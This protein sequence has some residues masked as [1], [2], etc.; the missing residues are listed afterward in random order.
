[1]KR[2]F[3][4]L[5]IVTCCLVVKLPIAGSQ[6][7]ETLSYQGVLGTPGGAI[8]T[9]GSYS[10]TFKLYES[11]SGGTAIW[12]E[13][14][15]VDVVN[16]IFS[17]ILGKTNP[18]SLSFNVPY[19]LGMSVNGGSEL[20]PRTELTSA[21]YS[22]QARSVID[23]AITS[24][25]I[26]SGQVV[27]S[28][29][30]LTDAVTL[31]A[32]DNITITPAGNT[33]TIS[34]A[35]GG[36]ES[37]SQITSVAAGEGLTGGGASG[38][39][40]LSLANNGVTTDKLNDGSVNQTKLADGAI[41]SAKI[42]QAAVSADK[43]AD[44]QVVKSINGL[45]DDIV[46][47]AQGGATLTTSGDTLTISASSNA[48]SSGIQGVQN[49]DNA[50]EISD[51]NGP[52]ATINVKPFGI[53]ASHLAAAAVTGDKIAA[54]QVVKSINNLQDN[55]IL[56][57]ADN[58]TVTQNGDTLKI[59]ASGGNRLDQ[60]YDQGG[61]GAGRTIVAD[62]GAV[63]I[64]GTGGLTV[65]GS[66]GI[67]TPTP[68]E[69]LHVSGTALM[70]GFKLSTNPA[71]GYVLK[72]DAA[73]V[74]SWQPDTLADG[75][76]T[77]AKIAAGQVVKS[78]NQ[79]TEA[80][81][82][83][84]EGGATITTQGDTLI[85]NAGSGGQGTGIQGLQNTNN[86]LDVFDPNGPTATV[87]LKELG[88][89]SAFL[90][91][92]SIIT[93][94]LSANAITGDKIA[95][96]QVVK[97][98][99]GLKDNLVLY[100]E[101]NVTVVQAGDT[102][103]IA[104]IGGNR[105]DQAYDQ[106]GAGAGRTIV[107]DAGAVDISSTGGLTVEGSV[108]IG[109]P[110]P[111][112]KLHVSGTALMTGFKLSTNPVEGYV[113]KSDAAGVGSWQPDTLTDG[114]VTAD[115]IA[116]GQVVKS[117]NNLRDN[118]ILTGADNVTVTQN[119][120]TLKIAASGGNRLN[121]AYDQG[122]AGAGR[123]IV[124]DA[125]AVDISGAG[126]LTVE[127]SVGIGT[128][129]PTEKLHVLGTALMTGFKLSTNPV[130][131]YV[132]KSDVAG[133][134]SWQPDTLADGSVTA[135]KIAA[136]Q[137][138]KSINQ[139]TEAVILKAEGGATIT[140][141]GDTL[142]IN[143]GSGGTLDD[144]YDKG[145]PGLG[146]TIVADAGPVAIV[147]GGDVLSKNKTNLITALAPTLL[148]VSG[149]IVM[150]GLQLNSV[151][152]D[153]FVL[154]SDA[155]GVASWQAD[156]LENDEVTG[157]KI[158][159][160]AVINSDL[161]D[162]SV[163]TP[164]LQ[165][166]VVTGSKIAVNQVVRSMNGLTE[167]VLVAGGDNVTVDVTGNTIRISTAVPGSNSW[168]L[169]GNSGTSA[170]SH[171]LGT[172]DNQPLEIHVNS[173]RVL[174]L[175]PTGGDGPNVIAGISANSVTSGVVGAT[176][177]G[178]GAS[179]GVKGLIGHKITD[180]YGTV[181]GGVQNQA[182]DNSGTTDDKEYATVGGG[183]AN[184]AT[185]R[186]STISGGQNNEASGDYGTVPGGFANGAI[187]KYSYAAGQRA[188]ANHDGT[189]V[190]ADKTLA[191][192]VSTGD[193]QFLIRAA[194]GVGIGTNAP[195]TALHITS[196]DARLRLDD[197]QD[198]WDLYVGLEGGGDFEIANAG[199]QSTA[200]LI[201][202]GTNNVG[203][204]TVTPG[205]RLDVAGNVHASGSIRSGNSITLDGNGE[206]DQIFS[207]TGTLDFSNNTLVTSGTV[208]IGGF[209]LTASP[210]AGSVLKSDAFGNGAWQ[211]DTLKNNSVTESKI[212]PGQVVRK[213]NSLTDDVK[214]AGGQIIQVVTDTVSKTIL[215]DLISQFGG[216]SSKRWK[217]NIRPIQ[218]ALEKVKQLQGVSYD[219]KKDGSHDIGLIAEEV[220]EIVPE[221]VTYEE[222]GIDA[223]IVNYPHLVA[224]LIESIKEQQKQIDTLR[225]EMRKLKSK[226]IK[227]ASLIH[228][229]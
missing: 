198:R 150:T 16:G 142:I 115:K 99:N 131:G 183:S 167:D 31:S 25:K 122:G 123:T 11:R 215:I 45:K 153:G 187:G 140:T 19:W 186:H 171:F 33:L 161:A 9:D 197:G 61:A 90:A 3:H 22:M 114:S 42:Q 220:G 172:T 63:D 120:D 211:P 208:E 69:K 166:G 222:N 111:T 36:A 112:E 170:S 181:A 83:K 157:A 60:A 40:T 176:I 177:G 107:A 213:V 94:K 214:I 98:I 125:G 185:G 86:T 137:V 155:T 15:S 47:R 168:S 41:S 59:A 82:L 144:A 100:G 48:E 141:Q 152:A 79:L 103:K 204:G 104:A 106:G 228:S 132:L 84:A 91:P 154:K 116:A 81:I 146:S 191:P 88:I 118:L 28:L 72:S 27:R 110:T 206:L 199:S 113:L 227:S 89:T 14:R 196:P 2:N 21:P 67:G 23:G 62:A 143:A 54:G 95:G 159:N 12:S 66:V 108:G 96:G 135:A 203:I 190:W 179:A 223:K 212:A 128:P 105:L 8:V 210:A 225:A 53:I 162:N 29:N 35:G 156:S 77:A 165:D 44:S 173:A 85:I 126:G 160:G 193:D 71:E 188:S 224:L 75:S 18:L 145:G 73:G 55:L 24:G 189:F 78:I 151:T 46:L 158:A 37:G 65:E 147:P 182:G 56:T 26:A 32:G 43:I 51:P 119:G 129:T 49:T 57:G 134:G 70:T 205:A 50:L 5:F 68:T 130:E 200:L 221:V 138:V 6:V 10:L 93:D 101:E 87:N 218:G 184:F 139:L 207:S 209:R 34:S 174:R 149:T 133:V 217:K 13:I 175:E 201:Q 136:G 80:V 109:T 76:V 20:T 163:S 102:L 226:K 74:G 202:T 180:N 124:A 121:Q 7:P 194:G 216:E 92:E 17:V 97:S 1:M 52:T 169:N 229:R 148:D 38:E 58:V 117:I 192:F 127:G 219:W 164:K 30:S 178:G 4:I 64:S 195:A 39:V